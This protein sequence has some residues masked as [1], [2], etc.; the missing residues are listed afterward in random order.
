[1]LAWQCKL[2]QELVINGYLVEA[3]NVVGVARLRGETLSRLEVSGVEWTPQLVDEVS[4]QMGRGWTP[5]PK[6]RL[7]SIFTNE[8]K[9]NLQ[10]QEEY[11]MRSAQKS[12]GEG[13]I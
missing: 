9:Y 5:L 7:N 10:L 2:L 12:F 1:M 13:G 4:K 8:G 3:L 11:V 6:T